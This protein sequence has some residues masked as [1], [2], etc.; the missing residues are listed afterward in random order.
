M[1]IKKKKKQAY[2]MYEKRLYSGSQ[3]NNTVNNDQTSEM[4]I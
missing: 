3:K 4:I 2:S 1:S